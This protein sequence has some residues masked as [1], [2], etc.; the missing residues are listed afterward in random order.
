MSDETNE[1]NIEEI[2]QEI[3]QQIL[4]RKLPGEVNLPMS[5]GKLPPDFYEHLYQA[6]LTQ[7][8]LGVKVH[9]VESSVP[10]IGGLIDRFRAAF[11]QLVIYYINQ[12]AEQQAEINGHLLGAL[13]ELGTY[14]E[15]QQDETTP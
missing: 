7:S 8:Q 4:D 1:V 3:R 13:T 10:L 14:L 11:H 2:M 15:A 6:N 9:V 12:V 5:G